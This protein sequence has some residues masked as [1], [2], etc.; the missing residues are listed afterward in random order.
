MQCDQEFAFCYVHQSDHMHV[1]WSYT[2]GKKNRPGR[3][4]DSMH[5][6]CQKYFII[7]KLLYL[8]LFLFDLFKLYTILK[9]WMCTF[10]SLF[11]FWYLRWHISVI[12]MLNVQ[13]N[14]GKN[15]PKFTPFSYLI[16]VKFQ[17]AQYKVQYT[18]MKDIIT[19]KNIHTHDKA[20]S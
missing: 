5:S 1:N 12:W 19:D 17:N 4:S 13:Y 8:W 9:L 14:K 15:T 20:H 3:W 2:H 16:L 11:P 6:H 7:C 18:K 10:R